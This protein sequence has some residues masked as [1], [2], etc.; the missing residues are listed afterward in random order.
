MIYRF[1]EYE[2]LNE[3]YYDD[4]TPYQYDSIKWMKNPVNIGWLDD[5]KD[6]PKGEVP[7]GFLNKL[8]SAPCCHHHKGSHSCPFCNRSRSSEVNYV[9]GDK[10]TYVFPNMLSH[11]ISKHE[12]KPP[13][14][15]IDAVMNLQ[16]RSRPVVAR[17]RNYKGK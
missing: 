2:K 1:E 16:E 9:V 6:Y 7:D 3:K 5:G 14:E 17:I 11:Y 8:A 15:F 12:Y 10:I 4:L 13:Q